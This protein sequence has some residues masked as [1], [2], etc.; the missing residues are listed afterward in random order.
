M[1]SSV[2]TAWS[3]TRESIR[4]HTRPC[5][6]TKKTTFVYHTFHFF[7]AWYFSNSEYKTQCFLVKN[8]SIV[9]ETKFSEV[10]KQSR[11]HAT[12][13][14]VKNLFNSHKYSYSN[15]LTLC[16]IQKVSVNFAF[17]VVCDADAAYTTSTFTI[18]YVFFHFI[19]T[20]STKH[21]ETKINKKIM[22]E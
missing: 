19:I 8:Q 9:I 10:T 13:T 4:D 20:N 2:D 18:Y 7:R 6:V 14:G 1:S 12:V 3:F 22:N 5:I 16:F 21:N 11:G 17:I 15:G